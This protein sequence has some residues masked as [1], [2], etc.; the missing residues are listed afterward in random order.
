MSRAVF[1]EEK[2]QYRWKSKPKNGNSRTL[3]TSELYE[4]CPGCN[5][6]AVRTMTEYGIRDDCKECKLTSWNHIGFVSQDVR[7]ARKNAHD[8]FDKLWK[9]KDSLFYTRTR[10]EVYERE[11]KLA[12][13]EDY[14]RTWEEVSRRMNRTDL[15]NPNQQ[16]IGRMNI[17]ECNQVIQ[18]CKEIMNAP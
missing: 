6:P 16:H 17:E 2:Q 5:Q 10:Y 11:Y 8:S 18:V 14:K 13:M 3:W 12:R 15:S 7:D 1:D 4:L 9:Y